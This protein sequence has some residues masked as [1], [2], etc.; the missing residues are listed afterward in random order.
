MGLFGLSNA[1]AVVLAEQMRSMQAQKDRELQKYLHNAQQKQ[2][3]EISA[4][5]M[6]SA[7]KQIAQMATEARQIEPF[8]SLTISLNDGKTSGEKIC[9]RASDIKEIKGTGHYVTWNEYDESYFRCQKPRAAFFKE[10]ILT[11][12]DSSILKVKES[13]EEV[14]KKVNDSINSINEAQAMILKKAFT[15]RE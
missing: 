14:Q 1:E 10:T 2:L 9:V 11:L 6:K 12:W 15:E 7:N 13:V 3:S 4:E 5:Q 8:I